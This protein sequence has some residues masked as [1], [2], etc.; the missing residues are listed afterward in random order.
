M[1]NGKGKADKS[2]A[3]A[4]WIGVVLAFAILITAWT[5]L[6]VIATRNQPEVI[7]IQEP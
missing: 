3:R 1:E 4:L 5:V 7:E 6:I 2:G